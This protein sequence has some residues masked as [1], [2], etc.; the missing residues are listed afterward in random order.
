MAETT[1]SDVA[2]RHG[3]HGDAFFRHLERQRLAEPV[4]T[5]FGGRMFVLAK[6]S[7]TSTSTASSWALTLATAALHES[8]S[9]MSQG[10]ATMS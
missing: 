5:G 1:G 3:V 7:L 9:A 4:H 8:M 6:R 10:A 2:R